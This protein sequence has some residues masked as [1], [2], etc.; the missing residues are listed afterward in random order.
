MLRFLLFYMLAPQTW[1]SLTL[2]FSICKMG[3]RSQ[4][5]LDSRTS[6]RLKG[7]KAVSGIW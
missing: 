4:L 7:T 5:C 6:R 2:S 1:F 3:S